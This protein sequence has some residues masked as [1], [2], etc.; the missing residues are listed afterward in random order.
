[1][2]FIKCLGIGLS[3]LCVVGCGGTQAVAGDQVTVKSDRG[4]A[5]MRARSGSSGK[6]EGR[7]RVRLGELD[8]GGSC[9]KS[10]VVRVVSRGRRGLEYCYAKG[11]GDASSGKGTVTMGWVI[12]ED[13]SVG[14]V[15]ARAS[16]LNNKRVE[17]C[18]QTMIRKW[19]FGKP[20][21]GDCKI[22]FPVVFEPEL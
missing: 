1:M 10:K 18:L 15:V 16:T 12:E 8:V 19:R 22:R 13:G 3:L 5:S 20:D 17:D 7:M 21:G 9:N 2:S 4:S 6:K 11:L 14:N